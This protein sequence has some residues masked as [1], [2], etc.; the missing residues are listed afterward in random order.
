MLVENPRGRAGPR[1]EDIIKIYVGEVDWFRLIAGRGTGC[2][3][4]GGSCAC[5]PQSREF[6]G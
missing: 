4:R 2:C 3:E 1:F 6:I 5:S